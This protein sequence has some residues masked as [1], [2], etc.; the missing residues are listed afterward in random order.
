[1]E[2]RLRELTIGE[3]IIKWW[4]FLTERGRRNQSE[5]IAIVFYNSRAAREP[6]TY[7]NRPIGV[8]RR[9]AI[10]IFVALIRNLL[11][12][13]VPSL[14]CSRYLRFI[15]VE[16]LLAVLFSNVC[17][18]GVKFD[19]FKGA[20]YFDKNFSWLKFLNPARVIRWSLSSLFKILRRNKMKTKSS[21]EVFN[22]TDFFSLFS[23]RKCWKILW[24]GPWKN[25]LHNKFFPLQTENWGKCYVKR[26]SSI[27]F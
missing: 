10:W 27:L 8:N 16:V 14:S 26:Y 6:P 3:N 1:M 18:W 21:L 12:C 13:Y 7:H 22:V 24:V 15:G 11:R 23:L 4:L 20:S 17:C 9:R 25:L 5:W 19:I 2:T